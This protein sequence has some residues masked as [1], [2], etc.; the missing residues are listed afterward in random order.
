MHTIIPAMR[1]ENGRVTAPF[2]VMGANYQPMGHV[3]VMVNT[4]IYGMDPQEALE[5]PRA[6]HDNGQL[7]IEEGVSD[8]VAQA[9]ADKGHTVSRKQTPLGGGQMIEIDWAGGTLTGGSDPRK[10]GLALGY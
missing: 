3:A 7:D 2:G 6:F 5:F 1:R 9:L 8:A 4:A 10:D